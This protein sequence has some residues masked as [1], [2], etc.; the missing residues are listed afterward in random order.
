MYLQKASGKVVGGLGF[1]DSS[2]AGFDPAG[3]S[4]EGEVWAQ[5]KQLEERKLISP[6]QPERESARKAPVRIAAALWVLREIC[7]APVLPRL[8]QRRVD[9]RSVPVDFDGGMAFIGQL[10]LVQE[11]ICKKLQCP[12]PV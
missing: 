2:T 1:E 8:P 12:A 6:A 9:A 3:R 4:G 7:N 5:S 11:D 10:I